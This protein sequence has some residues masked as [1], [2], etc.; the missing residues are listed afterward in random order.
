MTP[1][2]CSYARVRVCACAR[3]RVCACVR[4]RV[5]SCARAIGDRR[6][7]QV[8][9]EKDKAKGKET[10][11]FAVALNVLRQRY[12][13]E[14]VTMI[15][16]FNRRKKRVFR[17]LGNKEHVEVADLEPLR[18]AVADLGNALMDLEMRCVEQFEDIMN[19]FENKYREINAACLEA[20]Q[21]YFRAVEECENSYARDLM[22]LVNEL[23]EKAAKEELPED[24]PEEASNLLIDRDTC[25]NA[26][27]GSH[28]IHVGKLYKREEETKFN[29]IQHCTETIRNYRDEE[30]TRNRNRIIEIQEFLET[31][32]KQLN[33]LVTREVIDEYD[34]VPAE[35]F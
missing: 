2:V 3:V 21:S 26:I 1:C 27:T 30:H 32:R 13:S 31:N 10:A 28:D 16:E 9:L 4:V 25:L 14:S 34:D 19:E 33:D 15:E 35:N 22:T 11:R 8:G 7:A 6:S 20:Q 17:T 24:L 23:L 5:C 18:G 29:E 12:A